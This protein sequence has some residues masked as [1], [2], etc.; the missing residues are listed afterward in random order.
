M[1]LS[2]ANSPFRLT[3]N[4]LWDLLEADPDFNTHFKTK[5]HYNPEVTAGASAG[6]ASAPER[7]EISEADCPS[8][9]IDLV[10]MMPHAFRTSNGSSIKLLWAIKVAT[11]RR[12]WSEVLDSDW[13]IWR[14]MHDWQ[15]I[16]KP[17]VVWNGQQIVKSCY[18]VEVTQTLRDRDENRG[19]VGWS[20]AWMGVTELW[21]DSSE[22]KTLGGT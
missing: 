9:R 17:S 15:T 19:I 5:I 11:A 13:I 21:F 2:L 10:K 8:V 4:G 16:F 14:A 6:Y 20:T 18:T 3:Y 22:L 7:F 12:I 1:T